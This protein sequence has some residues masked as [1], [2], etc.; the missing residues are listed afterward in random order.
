MIRAL[1]GDAD[2]TRPNPYYRKAA[3][4]RL[5]SM[6]RIEEAEASP[7]FADRQAAVK[8]RS[9]ASASAADRRTASPEADEG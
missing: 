1:L 7:G 9:A 8:R 3:P 4:M 2:Q 6:R 5:W